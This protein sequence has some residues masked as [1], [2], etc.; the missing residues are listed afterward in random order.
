MT[1]EFNTLFETLISIAEKVDP[2][3]V[4]LTL[5]AAA[6]ALTGLGEKFGVSLTNSNTI[7]DDVNPQIPTDLTCGSSPPPRSQ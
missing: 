3:K 6:H 4:N 7:L 1:T 5:S 2:V